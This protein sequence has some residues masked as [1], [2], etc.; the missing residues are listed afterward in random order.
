M[1]EYQQTHQRIH[2]AVKVWIKCYE[3]KDKQGPCHASV[4]ADFTKM[5]EDVGEYLFN[6]EQQQIPDYSPDKE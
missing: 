4:L 5:L 2:K 1:D 3:E 6:K